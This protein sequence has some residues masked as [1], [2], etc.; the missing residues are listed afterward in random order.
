MF[1]IIRVYKVCAQTKILYKPLPMYLSLFS[2]IIIK[3]IHSIKN[4][5]DCI[6][7]MSHNSDYIINIYIYNIA[8]VNSER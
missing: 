2:P 4:S 8:F 1:L 5:A 6:V 3:R 7:F